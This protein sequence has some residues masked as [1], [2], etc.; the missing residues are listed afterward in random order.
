VYLESGSVSPTLR[1]LLLVAE[2]LEVGP[3]TLV[4]DLA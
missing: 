1:T 2:A 3:G 4:D